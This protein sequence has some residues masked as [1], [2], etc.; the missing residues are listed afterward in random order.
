VGIGA[1]LAAIGTLHDLNLAEMAGSTAR[2]AILGDGHLQYL[3]IPLA[4]C[5]VA[6][7]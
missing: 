6:P 5:L 4:H 1:A 3:G 2:N 7:H